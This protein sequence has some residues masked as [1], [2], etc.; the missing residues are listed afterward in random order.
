MSNN[1]SGGLPQ[2]LLLLVITAAACLARKYMSQGGTKP[3][4]GDPR[5]VPRPAHPF[6]RRRPEPRR[7]DA[8]SPSDVSAPGA[9]DGA[10]PVR[11][12]DMKGKEKSAAEV[13][14]DG[15]PEAAVAPDRPDAPGTEPRGTACP[16]ETGGAGTYAE[17]MLDHGRTAMILTEILAPPKALR[18]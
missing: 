11:P 9:P 3:R 12:D 15:A 4:S 10:A 2:N 8:C 17:L 18:K 7:R 14:T 13:R 1:S 6:P 5:R 16:T